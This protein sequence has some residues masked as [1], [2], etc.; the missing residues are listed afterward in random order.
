[1]KRIDRRDALQREVAAARTAG[2][3]IA[4]VPTMGYLHEGHLTL[5]DR[6]REVADVVVVSI[7]VNPLQ[8]GPG[9]DFERYP[10]DIERDALLAE[11]RGTDLLFVPPT[12]GLYPAGE[13]GVYVVAPRL[14]DRLCG[15]YRPGHFQGV[16]TVVA[17]L[18]NIVRPDIAVF[19]RK[20]FQ[21]LVLVRRMAADLDFA[22]AIVEGPI[23]REPDGLAMSSR[24]VYLSEDERRDATL[25]HA[26]LEDAQRAFT[27]GE[28]SADALIATAAR[29][30]EQGR[31]VQPQYIA[32]VHPETLDPVQ[33][34][35]VGSVVA[36]AGYV[37]KT[38]LIDNHALS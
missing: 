35:R 8:F 14:A 22:V 37:G 2:R 17:K 19:G 36:L 1:V 15:A 29:R 9:E 10:R 27:A 12:E 26:A 3:R 33:A 38:R 28:R 18:F 23:V 5:I 6:A 24:N 11:A 16:L 31:H 34:A 21:Q 13:P 7:F 32:L 30:I 4:L 25:L 20:D